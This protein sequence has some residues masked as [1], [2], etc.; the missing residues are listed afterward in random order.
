MNNHPLVLFFLVTETILIDAVERNFHFEH[1]R[2]KKP[3]TQSND[4]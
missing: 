3:K 2:V 1:R 4:L